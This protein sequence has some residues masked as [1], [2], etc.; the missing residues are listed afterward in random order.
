MTSDEDRGVEMDRPLAT[1]IFKH[2]VN[3]GCSINE[4]TSETEWLPIH[5]A[6][7]FID[8]APEV[9]FYI[10][11]HGADLNAKLPASDPYFPGQ[12][13]LEIADEMLKKRPDNQNL[14]KMRELL[15]RITSGSIR[16]TKADAFAAG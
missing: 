2:L 6:I 8:E 1:R 5:T 11:S 4:P 15:T 9:A 10:A 13:A 3:S 16:P 14:V 7:V 12:S